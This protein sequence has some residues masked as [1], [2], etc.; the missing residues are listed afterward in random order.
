MQDAQYLV[1]TAKL[2]TDDLDKLVLTFQDANGW[3]AWRW[4]TG[5]DIIEERRKK[6]VIL[7]EVLTK[8]GKESLFWKWMEI[9]E[10]ERDSDGGFTAARQKKVAER[11]QREF[12]KNGVDFEEIM[13][14]IGGL[15]EMPLQAREA[16]EMERLGI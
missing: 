4:E 9:V 15:E 3:L 1:K 2:T 13:T 8:L 5:S 16:E 11:V 12:E 14:G 10:D 7:K 6:I